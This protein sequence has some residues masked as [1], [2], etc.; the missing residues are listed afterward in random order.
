MVIC[1]TKAMEV[2][3]QSL[4]HWP[5]L[6]NAARILFLKT[7][8]AGAKLNHLVDSVSNIKYTCFCVNVLSSNL[9]E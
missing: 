7:G 2:H 1:A 5:F 8:C 6:T 3:G 4:V 9:L